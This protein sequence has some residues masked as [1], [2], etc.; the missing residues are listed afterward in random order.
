MTDPCHTCGGYNNPPSATDII[1][2]YSDRR[3]DGI[4]LIT[5]KNPPYQGKLA[6]PGGFHERGISLPENAAKE[7]KEET[8]LEI[9]IKGDPE[10]PL[11]VHSNPNR[12]PRKH[13]ISITYVAKGSGVLRVGDDA[14]TATLYSIPDIID[15]LG[16]NGFAFDH[17][18]ALRKYLAYRAERPYEYHDAPVLRGMEA[19]R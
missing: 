8:N 14:A 1:I 4:V 3:K 7:A 9:I 12:D 2:E 10:R 11:C 19:F 6:L 16:K 15:L 17:E 5:R 18:R 13:I